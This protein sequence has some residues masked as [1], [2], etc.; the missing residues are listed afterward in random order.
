MTYIDTESK[1]VRLIRQINITANTIGYLDDGKA[2]ADENQA[3]TDYMDEIGLILARHDVNIQ[4]KS[5]AAIAVEAAR[6][7]LEA[8]MSEADG[9]ERASIIGDARTLC[10]VAEQKLR[11][12]AKTLD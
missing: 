9:D 11:R 10:E 8:N 4:I 3:L 2:E 5:A 6:L 12:Y 7:G 1:L